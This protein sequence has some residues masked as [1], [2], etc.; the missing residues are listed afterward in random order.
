MDRQLFVMDDV[1]LMGASA[2]SGTDTDTEIEAPD[3]D[4]TLDIDSRRQK[5][6]SAVV[7][8]GSEPPWAQL[9]LRYPTYVT[10]VYVN[11][12]PTSVDTTLGHGVLDVLLDENL[13]ATLHL[14]PNRV[15]YAIKVDSIKTPVTRLR[16]RKRADFLSLFSVSRSPS[17]TRLL[18]SHFRADVATHSILVKNFDQVGGGSSPSGGIYRGIRVGCF[19]TCDL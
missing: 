17:M 15:S 9:L 4:A 13:V 12:A 6:A 10:H 7:Q 8:S 1:G 3:S 14:R 19:T 18:A 2:E 16:V 5:C 11:I